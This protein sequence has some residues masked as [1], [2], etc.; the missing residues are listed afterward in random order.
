[1]N[2]IG[3]VEETTRGTNPGSGFVF[4]PTNGNLWPSVSYN[5]TT[6]KRFTGRSTGSSDTAPIRRSGR[7]SYDLE[8]SLY[9][10][11]A[12]DLLF[13]HLFGD[14]TYL[15]PVK[16]PYGLGQSLGSSAIG[17][18][19]NSAES[20][21]TVSRYYGGGRIK[22]C[23][24]SGSSGDLKIIFSLVGP[25]D[26]IG[27]ESTALTLGTM[28]D[29]IFD[30]TGVEIYIGSGISRA[31]TAPYYTL[32]E[33][34]TMELVECDSFTLTINNGLS[35]KTINNGVSG[36][37]LTFRSD[38]FSA[39]LSLP[40]SWDDIDTF[41]PSD[42]YKKRLVDADT[43]SFLVIISTLVASYAFDIPG[44]VNNTS[45]P[46]AKPEAGGT[47]TLE[48]KSTDSIYGLYT[49]LPIFHD[50]C[51]TLDYLTTKTTSTATVTVAAGEISFDKGTN[52]TSVCA[53]LSTWALDGDSNFDITF[54]LIAGTYLS[55]FVGVAAGVSWGANLDDPINVSDSRPYFYFS[56]GG[57]TLRADPSTPA[58]ITYS[59]GSL[60]SLFCRI[61]YDDATDTLSYY[62][63]TSET[64][65][66][67]D[68]VHTSVG[69][70]TGGTT[71]SV[72]LRL[73]GNNETAF[74]TIRNCGFIDDIKVFTGTFL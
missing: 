69:E 19:V 12:L 27:A 67:G 46:G 37:S 41:T 13:K 15:Y 61:T 72:G 60:A 6:L 52:S 43:N 21:T 63:R 32:L 34:G 10:G 55:E 4:M 33:P 26:Y 5:D 73:T 28:P 29:N 17:L 40:M 74:A 48:Y 7:W 35:D 23:S 62:G 24:I 57:I 38:L 14:T 65:E 8:A 18:S 66:W 9:S 45:A 2:Y 30:S 53:A 71:R 59:W 58:T 1:M 22:S 44:A 51:S 70:W 49:I 20:G 3:L 36:P 64:E 50:T 25:A 39:S 54:K 56:N 31:G 42:E 11:D 47:I 16:L 68:P